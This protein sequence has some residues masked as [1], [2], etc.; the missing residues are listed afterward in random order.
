MA[1]TRNVS[2][3]DIYLSSFLLLHGI[4]PQFE[5]KNGKVIFIFPGDDRVYRLMN[6]FNNNA[7]VPV[8]DF[9]TI[10]KTLRGK[11]LTFKEAC[12][13]GTGN[14]TRYRASLG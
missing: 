13:G 12:I 11:M 9:A 5:M 4:E 6:L 8:A 1:T 14:E 2:L 7:D 10:I 3:L